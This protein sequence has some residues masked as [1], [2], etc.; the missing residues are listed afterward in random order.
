MYHL[1]VYDKYR[2]RKGKGRMKTVGIEMKEKTSN[3]RS[4]YSKVYI[5]QLID[6]LKLQRNKKTSRLVTQNLFGIDIP[7]R[8][9][10]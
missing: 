8:F 9:L 3:L 6:G 10:I 7:R 4:F 1:R 2:I 5:S